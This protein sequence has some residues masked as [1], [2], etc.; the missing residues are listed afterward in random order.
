MLALIDRDGIRVSVDASG[1][2]YVEWD[3]SS[4]TCTEVQRQISIFDADQRKAFA[5]EMIRRWTLAATS[6]R[7]D[8]KR[9][10]ENH[11]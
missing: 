6:G 9:G 10:N 3:D 2:I 7:S 5:Q 8:T 4:D 11:G 1:E